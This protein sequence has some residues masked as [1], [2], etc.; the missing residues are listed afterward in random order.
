MLA[1]FTT[2]C[3]AD[4]RVALV[5]G[6]GLYQKVP[7]LANPPRDATDIA[8]SLQ[9]LNFKVLL[10]NN[11]SASD[12]RKA[13]VEFGRKADGSDIAIVFYAG[14]GMEEGGENWLIPT[15]AELQSDTDV[16][17]EA[18]SLRSINLQVG[19]AHQLGLVIL[20]ACRNNPFASKM[21]RSLSTRAVER[22]LVRTEPTDNVLVAYA[23]RDGTTA[24]DGTGR[25]SPFT[26]AL[27]H[28]IETPGLEISFLFRRV[29]DD[30]MSATKR[31]QQP[32]VYG[33]LSKDEIYLKPPANGTTET[34]RKPAPSGED[35]QFWKAIETSDVTGLFEE[36][37]KR[38]PFSPH[39]DTARERIASLS[40]RPAAAKTASVDPSMQSQK[41]S[42]KR[43]L[44]SAADIGRLNSLTAK[45][46][47]NPPDFTSIETDQGIPDTLRRFVGVWANKNG[48][49]GG[50]RTAMILVTKVN[51]DGTATGRYLWGPPTSKSWV[52]DSAGSTTFRGSIANGTLEFKYAD[53]L[54]K[55]KLESPKMMAATVQEISGGKTK[56]ARGRFEAV[57]QLDPSGAA[58]TEHEK[59][60]HPDTA[61]K[62]PVRSDFEA[63]KPARRPGPEDSS[64]QV[65]CGPSG[66][67]DVPKGCRVESGNPAKPW[68]VSTQYQYIV[69]N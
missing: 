54:M 3:F 7:T 28:H 59:N 61:K 15:D 9:R 50:G 20:D 39:V 30:V 48:Y 19:K 51:A 62:L 58:S 36:F 5:I 65:A 29:R 8:S 21:K 13:L 41:D 34:A 64:K 35:E 4:E 17:A 27:L 6:N 47:L 53:I 33:S 69:C 10:L 45:L 52:Q 31:E 24:L 23:A 43:N 38:Y 40:A 46:N 18:I 37:V 49:E 26:T 14:H 42:E 25:N 22:G 32:F 12:M 11:A 68:S 55:G 2:A 63:P 66:C 16:E 67:R 60:K 1:C 57:W 56:T 44:L